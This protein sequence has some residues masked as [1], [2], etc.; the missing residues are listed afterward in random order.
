MNSR[1]LISG[2]I[3]IG[4]LAAAAVSSQAKNLIFYGNSFTIAVGFGSTRTVPD[5]VRDIA[6]AAGQPSPYIVNPSIAGWSLQ[7]H[8]T[9]NTGPITTSIAPG[10]TWD[11]VILQDFSTQPTQI[12]NLALHRSSYKSMYEAVRA[13]SPNVRAVGYETWARAP[14]HSFY[15]GSNPSFPGGAAQMQQQVRDG[16]ALSTADV[17]AAYGAGTSVVSPAGDAWENAGFPANLYASDLYHAQNRGS[18]LS[19]LTLYSTIYGDPTVSDIDLT[20]I[21]TGLSLTPADGVFLT[22]VVDRTVPEPT[23]IGA[24]LLVAVATLARRRRVEV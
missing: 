12:G 3:V 9:S 13:H 22:S 10:Q 6:V 20:S 5:L 18:L 4:T 23:A 17:N 11:V 21:L 14:G 7:Q 8:R 16:Y 24:L 2:L 1:P 15:T 19:A